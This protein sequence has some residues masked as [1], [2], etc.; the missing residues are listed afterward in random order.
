MKTSH[1]TRKGQSNHFTHVCRLSTQPNASNSNPVVNS[2]H[3]IHANLSINTVGILRQYVI[4]HLFITN[5]N[6]LH[7]KLQFCACIHAIQVVSIG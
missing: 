1:T 2:V 4:M 7:P 5:W 6:I 3:K